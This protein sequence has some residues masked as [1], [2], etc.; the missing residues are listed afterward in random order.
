[1]IIRT[2][3]DK[4]ELLPK[5]AHDEDA[6][7]DLITP[8]SIHLGALGD[9]ITVNTGVKIELP[10]GYFGLVQGKSGLA[11]KYNITTI[12]NII[13]EGYEGYIHVM[14]MNLSKE[15]VFLEAG[16]KIAQLIVLPYAKVSYVSVNSDEIRETRKTSRGDGKF[17]STGK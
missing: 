12:G 5:R 4:E 10:V 14:L 9:K 2:T 17:G 7:A 16:S 11:N 8:Y 3:L 6:G 15:T 13:D 1:M